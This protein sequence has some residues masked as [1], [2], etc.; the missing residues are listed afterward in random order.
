MA[1]KQSII[2]CVFSVVNDDFRDLLITIWV[3]CG[4]LY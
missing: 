2:L 4:S 3:I 1:G